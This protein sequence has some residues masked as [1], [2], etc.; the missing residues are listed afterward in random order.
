MLYFD[1]TQYD[2]ENHFLGAFI[3]LQNPCKYE[4]FVVN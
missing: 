4:G 3:I 1:S 2:T